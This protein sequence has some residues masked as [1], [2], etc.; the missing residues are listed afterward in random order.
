MR[1]SL[2]VVCCLMCSYIFAQQPPEDAAAVPAERG[3]KEFQFYPGGKVTVVSGMPGAISI[4]GWEKGR[5]RVESETVVRGLGPDGG[6]DLDEGP[7]VRVRHTPTSATIEVA[8]DSRAGRI[9]ECN[10]VVR[11][12]RD[13]TDIAVTAARGDIRVEG[14]HGW[15][16]VA[17]G[18]GDLAAWSMSGYFSGR[19]ER[20][21]IRVAMSGS[22]W[23]GLEFGAVTRM[24]SIDVALPADY[25]A[26]LQFEARNG[27]VA[28]DY[29]PQTI[30]GEEVPLKVGTR[31]KAQALHAGVGSGGAPIKLVSRSGDIRLS[32]TE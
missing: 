19:T 20:G 11:V 3:E 5:V 31:K 2:M 1:T 13:K 14:V 6:E 23:Q 24:G 17:T 25:S 18:E 8:G 30:D 32:T 4:V 15:I 28:V 21:D 26:V 10:L 7:R 16:E 29:P 12:P 9:L 27:K 22:C